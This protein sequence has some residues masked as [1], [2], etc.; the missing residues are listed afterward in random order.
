MFKEDK[1]FTFGQ[2]A[3]ERKQIKSF[4]FK[5]DDLVNWKQISKIL[6]PGSSRRRRS[7]TGAYPY[8]RI[9]LFKALLLQRW[10]NLSDYQLEDQLND[11]L[12]FMK[13]LGISIDSNTPLTIQL[14]VDSET[15][16]LK[17]I[18]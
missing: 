3:V 10:F 8:S 9:F 2:M 15:N 6:S 14:F 7:S 1:T 4:L 5:I 17:E 11:R 12:S 18:Y 13:F 16:F